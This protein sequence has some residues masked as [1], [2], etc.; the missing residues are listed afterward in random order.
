[1]KCPRTT[2]ITHIL[3]LVVFATVT[4]QSCASS[5]QCPPCDTIIEIREKPTFYPV[6]VKI[7][8]LEPLVLPEVPPMAPDGATVEEKKAAAIA[9]GKATEEKIEILIARD[10]AWTLKVEQHNAAAEDAGPDED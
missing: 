8:P 2:N 3:L 1:M 7:T 6:I 5:P 4:L 10:K 9:V